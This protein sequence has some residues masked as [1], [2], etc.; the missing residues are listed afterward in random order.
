VREKQFLFCTMFLVQ[1]EIKWNTEKRK[2]KRRKIHLKLKSQEYRYNKR[3]K[4][5]T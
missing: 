1:Q 4:L 2:E 5:G 3:K